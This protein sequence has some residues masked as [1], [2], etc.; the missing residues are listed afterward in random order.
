MLS[1][2]LVQPPALLVEETAFNAYIS[3]SN[4]QPTG[5]SPMM[6]VLKCLAQLPMI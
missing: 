4:E 1:Y 2:L 5:M 6:C 3:S